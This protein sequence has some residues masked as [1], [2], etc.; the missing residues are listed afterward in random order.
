MFYTATFTPFFIGLLKE[1]TLPIFIVD[2]IIDTFFIV[3][4]VRFKSRLHGLADSESTGRSE[5][6]KRL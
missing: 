5:A 6:C 4:M 2:R 3:D 1:A